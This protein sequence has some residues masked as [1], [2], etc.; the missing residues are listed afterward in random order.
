MQEES[1]KDLSTHQQFSS[2]QN[3][4]ETVQLSTFGFQLYHDDSYPFRHNKDKTLLVW[5]N[6][7]DHTRI[8]SMQKGGDMT[9]V[10]RRF[11][12][13]ISKVTY[14]Y[15]KG[16]EPIPAAPIETTVFINSKAVAD[17]L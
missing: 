10:F 17:R 16:Q 5:I 4:K 15:S 13:G 14:H 6:E 11:C 9:A 1:G 7:E 12:E 2:I 3:T 8:I